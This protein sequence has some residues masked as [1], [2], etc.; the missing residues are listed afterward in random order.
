MNFEWDENKRRSNQQ[1]HSVDFADVTAVFFDEFT[2]SIEDPDHHN[3]QRF[4]AIGMSAKG[5]LVVVVYAYSDGDT[6]RI[7]SARRADRPERKI[8][9]G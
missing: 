6:I 2:I 4:I 1:K 5:D 3:E 8:Y 9:E 7:I